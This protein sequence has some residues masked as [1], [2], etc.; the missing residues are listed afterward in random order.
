MKGFQKRLLCSKREKKDKV[1]IGRNKSLFIHQMLLY[2]H[3]KPHFRREYSQNYG[4][5]LTTRRL[6]SRPAEING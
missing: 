3:V 1:L 2:L 6:L 4:S 5:P